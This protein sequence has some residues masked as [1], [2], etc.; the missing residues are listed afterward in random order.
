MEDILAIATFRSAQQ[1]AK[2]FAGIIFADD[3]DDHIKAARRANMPN[4]Q[5][6]LF[7]EGRDKKELVTALAMLSNAK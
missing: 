7:E 4:V 6:I 2:V 5:T 3:S 1:I